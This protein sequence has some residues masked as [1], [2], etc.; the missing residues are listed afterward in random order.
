MLHSGSLEGGSCGVLEQLG[1]VAGVDDQAC[2][3][4]SVSQLSTSQEDLVRLDGVCCG[5]TA[6]QGNP[7]GRGRG[8]G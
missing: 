1:V 2:Y 8:E 3:V 7:G 5:F 6:A 4:A